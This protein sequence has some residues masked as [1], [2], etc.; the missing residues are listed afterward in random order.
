[1]TFDPSQFLQMIAS[2]F[3]VFLGI[4]PILCVIFALAWI[5]DI[6]SDTRKIRRVLQKRFPEDF[7]DD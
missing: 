1:M 4:T 5:R 3:G 7:A 6:R 2:I